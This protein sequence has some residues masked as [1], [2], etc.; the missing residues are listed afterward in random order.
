MILSWQRKTHETKKKKSQVK[1]TLHSLTEMRKC[2]GTERRRA[3]VRISCL[4]LME[5]KN[6]ECPPSQ[7]ERGRP[8]KIHLK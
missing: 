8:K 7:L 6:E 2:H 4:S 5:K 3:Q 1:W